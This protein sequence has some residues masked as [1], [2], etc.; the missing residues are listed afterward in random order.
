MSARTLAR[1]RAAASGDGPVQGTAACCL[2][3]AR[4]RRL[5]PDPARLEATARLCTAGVISVGILASW[6]VAVYRAADVDTL[7]EY[8]RLSRKETIFD[9]LAYGFVS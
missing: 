5:H 7:L 3:R 9:Y 1:R 8:M 4:R 2:L 6:Y